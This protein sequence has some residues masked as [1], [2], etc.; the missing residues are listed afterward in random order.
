[1]G[2][3]DAQSTLPAPRGLSSHGGRRARA[4]ERPSKQ[5]VHPPQFTARVDGADR[6]GPGLIRQKPRDLRT[7]R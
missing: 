7:A 6:V 2:T 1:M 4:A 5:Q 3:V